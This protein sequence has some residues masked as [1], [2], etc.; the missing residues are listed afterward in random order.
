MYDARHCLVQTLGGMPKD[1]APIRVE[2]ENRM[3]DDMDPLTVAAYTSCQIAHL[4]EDDYY[5][6]H[7][8]APLWLS[9]AQTIA[10]V[11]TYLVLPRFQ[12][13]FARR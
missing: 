8:P 6:V 4:S 9:P 10:A 12:A 1:K 11:C 7:H 3:E 13:G 2:T 5:R